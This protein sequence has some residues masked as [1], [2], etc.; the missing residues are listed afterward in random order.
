MRSDADL[1]EAIAADRHDAFEALFDTHA[2]FVF[3]IARRRTGS[4]AEAEDVTAEVF[5]ELW[6]K[7]RTVRTHHGSLRPWLAGTTT[8]LTHRYWR[9]AER[10]G[11]ALLRLASRDGATSTDFADRTVAGVDAAGQLD[12]L[13]AAL[14]DLPRD[15][16][17]VLTL[18]VW[19]ELTH[20]EIAEALGIA[21]GTVKSRLSRARAAL[22]ESLMG[23]STG[24]ESTT[25]ESTKTES[26]RTDSEGTGMV[27]GGIDH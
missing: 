21:V 24:A 12:G 15:Q 27:V 10:R 1:L 9:T 18:S 25:A 19:E 8:N 13:R 16:F 22:T 14:L 4:A 26:T 2:D 17:D 5:T 20:T 6:R 3:N 11:R 7:R 23:N